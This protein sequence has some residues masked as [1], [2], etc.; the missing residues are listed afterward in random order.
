MSLYIV[1]IHGELE[2]DYEEI[3]KY[4]P[5]EDAVSRQQAIEVL[6]DFECD[7]ENG[8]E[9]SFAKARERM[10]DLP[11]VQP[12]S[13][14]ISVKDRLP[15]E[16]IAVLIYCPEIKCKFTA[17][18]DLGAWHYFGGGCWNVVGWHVSDWM[19]LPEHEDNEEG[20]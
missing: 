19:P 3:C 13:S 18:R 5:C 14:W 12:K 10:C 7:I 4:E 1:D 15:N 11:S 2:G 6:E 16:G 9:N 20:E 8:K 17:I